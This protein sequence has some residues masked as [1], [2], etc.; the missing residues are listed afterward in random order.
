MSITQEYRNDLKSLRKQHK[1]IA[2]KRITVK[3]KVLG[4]EKETVDDQ[5]NDL[6]KRDQRILSEMISS[7]EYALF[8]LEN[9][10]EQPY[11]KP[12]ANSLPKFMR[13]QLWGD[14]DD[15]I[16]WR[17]TKTRNTLSWED[18]ERKEKRTAE[19]QNRIDQVNEIVSILSPREKELFQLR[20]AALLTE[21]ECAEKLGVE[22]GTVKSMS[23][24]IRDKIDNYFKYGYQMELF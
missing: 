22:K 2:D 14:I 12:F 7:T 23:Q 3:H 5:R 13:E 20:F 10:Y 15:C 6:E 9:G 17:T 11:D 16:R 21:K 8:W 19:K 4:K 1:D 18:Q 24:R